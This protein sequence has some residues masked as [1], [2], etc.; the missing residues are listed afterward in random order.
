MRGDALALLKLIPDD[1]I[2]S[3]VTDPPYYGDGRL[4]RGWD[5]GTVTTRSTVGNLPSGMA[6]DSRQGEQ[7]VDFLLP[8]AREML[9]VAKPGALGAVFAAPRLAHG[10]MR[11]FELAGWWIRDQW[12][13]RFP[14]GQARAM[15][16][17][18]FASPRCPSELLARMATWKTP[19]ATPSWESV[20]VIQSPPLGTLTQNWE[21]FG[22]GLLNCEEG[23]PSTVL[24]FAR[25]GRAERV[26]TGSHPTPKPEALCRELVRRITPPGGVVLDPFLGSG[27]TAVAAILEGHDFVG[28]EM[29]AEYW[30]IIE[31]RVKWAE[32]EAKREAAKA[33][34]GRLIE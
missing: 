26:R 31:A 7:M 12:C 28:C 8:F 9:R 19:Q 29:T 6:F 2:E 21:K 11:A 17:D 22:C 16:L 3:I 5:T 20:V 23:P 25:P 24:E 30:P 32:K 14:P 10:T 33:K 18:R 27:T 34:Q 4:G 1:S 15:R 13:W